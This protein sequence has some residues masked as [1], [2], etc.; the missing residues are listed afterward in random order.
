MEAI[1]K[2]GITAVDGKVMGDDSLWEKSRTVPSWAWEDVGNY[3][4]AGASALT[5]HEN[6]YTLFS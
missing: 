6:N 2:Q 4:G 5:F 1:Q 3:Y